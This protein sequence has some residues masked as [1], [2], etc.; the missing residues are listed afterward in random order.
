MSSAGSS[1][2]VDEVKQQLASLTQDQNLQRV[3]LELTLETT[4][5]DSR[6]SSSLVNLM[7]CEEAAVRDGGN[8]LSGDIS[9]RV[10]E[11]LAQETH[12]FFAKTCA[13]NIK[14]WKA[15][16][17][18]LERE[19]DKQRGLLMEQVARLGK[20]A[21]PPQA[22]KSAAA[23]AGAKK[24]TYT[25]ED[26]DEEALR[27]EED[28]N[29]NFF[30]YEGF[31]LTEA[32]KSQAAKVDK[33]WAVHELALAEDYK[34]RRRQLTGDDGRDVA[35]IGT[36]QQDND[37]ENSRWQHPEKQ[38]TL[39]HTAP[40]LVPIQ[41]GA[42]SPQQSSAGSAVRA[43]RGRNGPETGRNAKEVRMCACVRACVRALAWLRHTEPPLPP[44]HLLV[45]SWSAWTAS[46]PSRW[47]RWP[48]RRR[49]PCAGCRGRRSA[50][51]R[52]LRKCVWSMP[53]LRSY[54][55]CSGKTCVP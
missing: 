36:K 25:S 40:V 3:Q 37:Q 52:R 55:P 17:Q 8:A 19:R 30:Q 21:A 7:K 20:H 34:A 49:A 53:R 24:E 38:K 32:F 50:S 27:L 48:T 41:N 33:D 39:I 9:R 12:K 11:A 15:L 5:R 26:L 35:K 47:N 51:T 2:W 45:G 13:Q 14:R 1:S 18:K 54:L 42:N 16:S 46:T 23:G 4:P 43:V 29:R 44:S 6:Y 31:N 28:Y 22:R 10:D